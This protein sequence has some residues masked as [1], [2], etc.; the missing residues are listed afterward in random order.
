VTG[1]PAANKGNAS[2]GDTPGG[3]SGVGEGRRSAQ[4]QV[5]PRIGCGVQQ[6]RKAPCG[7]N[8]RSRE[9]RQGRNV[10]GNW[11]TRAPGN[12]EWTH[13]ADVDGGAVFEE[14]QERS[15]DALVDFGQPVGQGPQR[16]QRAFEVEARD[17]SE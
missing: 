14:P 11:Q 8:R 4:N 3:R 7:A 12:R 5:N 13:E 16:A 1:K 17:G 9:E 6:T 2:K 10:L 15:P